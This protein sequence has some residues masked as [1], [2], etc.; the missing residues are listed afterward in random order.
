VLACPGF[1][2]TLP[3]PP[4]SVK[5]ILADHPAPELRTGP[6]SLW[7]VAELEEW[8]R[9]HGFQLGWPHDISSRYAICD[10]E[11]GEQA[12]AIAVAIQRRVIELATAVWEKHHWEGDDDIVA[13]F[14]PR[15]VAE[16]N[17]PLAELVI[18]NEQIN[19]F[20][21]P[22]SKNLTWA[23]AGVRVYL[24]KLKGL[25]E[26]VQAIDSTTSNLA[27]PTHPQVMRGAASRTAPPSEATD[28]N[29]PE[30]SARLPPPDP[31]PFSLANHKQVADS[32]AAALTGLPI[33]RATAVL[34]PE[35]KTILRVLSKAGHALT[36]SQIANEAANLVRESAQAKG[37]RATQ[38]AGLM[39]LSET[40]IGERVP[41]LQAQGLISR[42]MGRDGKPTSRKGVGITE[43][44]AAL[45]KDMS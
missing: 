26:Q 10:F 42:P 13:L 45:L 20:R 4:R 34:E 1:N 9:A 27:S 2:Q 12:D 32:I 14:N 7:E 44:G 11:R 35:D 38:G 30:T 23:E 29:E 24:S 19:R 43:K 6:A 21:N 17:L 33:P 37:G 41:I 28:P 18:A 31:Y 39:T 36:Y 16:H 22:A 3:P 25:L 40:K 5:K 8:Q 15:F